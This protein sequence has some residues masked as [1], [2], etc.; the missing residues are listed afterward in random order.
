[1]AEKIVVLKPPLLLCEPLA[2][3]KMKRLLQILF[4][5]TLTSCGQQ[6][7]PDKETWDKID[8][9]IKEVEPPKEQTPPS[10]EYSIGDLKFIFSNLTDPYDLGLYQRIEVKLNDSSQVIIESK[11]LELEGKTFELTPNYVFLTD[12]TS[13]Y[14]ITANNRPEPNYYYILKRTEQKVE[15]VG[16][17]EPLTKELFGDIDK[18][19]HLEIGGFNTHCQGATEE[20]FKDPDFCLDHFRVFEIKNGI[21]RDEEKER[22]NVRQQRV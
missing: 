11:T 8:E 1:M 4:L 7:N 2:H 15:L 12:S 14:L 10:I 6:Q 9:T 18:D 19:G 22:K 3:I 21:Y 20:D 17:T 13:Y 16:Q 5:L